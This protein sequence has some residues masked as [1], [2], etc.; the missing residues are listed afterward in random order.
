MRGRGL[1]ASR[2]RLRPP[3]ALLASRLATAVD[4]HADVS[5]LL[6]SRLATTAVDADADAAATSSRFF[7]W[8]D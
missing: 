2:L 4:A 8:A 1:A 5:A 7:V 3:H 6:A